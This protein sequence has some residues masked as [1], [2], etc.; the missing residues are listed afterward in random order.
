VI[1]QQF[2][3]K[4]RL[5]RAASI[6]WSI[7]L[8]TWGIAA[9]TGSKPAG[10]YA[11]VIHPEDFA[12][13]VD[14]PY[15]PLVPGTRFRY[16]GLDGATSETIETTVT[17]DQKV[18]MGVATTVVHERE[19]RNGRLAEE[20]FDWYAQH[21]DGTVWYFGE[22]SRTLDASGNVIDTHG[23]WEAGKNGALPGIF[24]RARPR[25]G[26]SYRQEYAPRIAEDWAKVTSLSGEALVVQGLYTRCVVLLEWSPLEKGDDRTKKYFAK[27]VG[28]VLEESFANDEERL[29]LESI[30][31]P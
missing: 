11:P 23:S 31:P 7:A 6:A 1:E 27:G 12:S 26:E 13:T 20:T 8:A 30:T 14:H 19:Y 9:L 16:S 15:F 24:M 17:H 5:R 25:V 2:S 10:P 22:D 3:V 29:E 18:V 21:K 4:N 28:L